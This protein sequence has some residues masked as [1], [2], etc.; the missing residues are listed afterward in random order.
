MTL[1]KL[2]LLLSLSSLAVPFLGC[3]SDKD[4]IGNSGGST[5]FESDSPSGSSQSG[6]GSVPSAAGP[7]ASTGAAA[8]D[9]SNSA[10]RAIE[11]A[12]IVKVENDRL[13]ALSQYG[14]LNIIDIST[15]DNLRLLGRKKVQ[16]QPFEMY[17]RDSIVFALY[18]GYGEYIEGS[19]AG[20]W[21]YIT[22][23]YVIAFDATDPTN[24]NII[25]KFAVPGNISDSRI[26]GDVLYVV[27]FESGGCWGC[28]S[29]QHTTVIS[30]DVST[31]SQITKRDQL[32]FAEDTT[33]QWSWQRSISVTDKRMYVAGPSYSNNGPVGSEIQ[34]ID[35]SD[36]KGSLVTG[37][38]VQASGSV[39]SRWQMD[40]FNGTLRV[41]S[42]PNQWL[43][44][45]PVRIQTYKV[46]S[47]QSLTQ[48]ANV[49]MTIPAGESLRSVRFDGP[50]GYAITAVQKDPLFTIDLSDPVQPRQAGEL[51]MPGWVYYMEPRGE[52]VVG[53]GYDQGN[54]AGALAISLFDVSTL[55]QPKLLDRVNFG[56]TWSWINEG[57]DQVHKAFQVLDA[58]NL[59][60]MPFSGWVT[61]AD[62]CS[63]QSMNGIQLVD[64]K[65]DTLGLRGVASMVG[66]PRRGLLNNERLFAMSDD[67]VETFDITDR[68][69]PA[70]K[71]SIKL[72]HRVQSTLSAG[73]TI[74]ELA[75][76][77]YS[78]TLSLDTTT[79]AAVESADALGH[80]DLSFGSGKC[81]GTSLGTVASSSNRA[82]LVV[83]DYSYNATTGEST[84]TA[85]VVTVDVSSP[86]SPR[87]IGEA[88][89]DF[90]EGWTNW[91]GGNLVN[92]GAQSVAI[93][94]SMVI[95]ST[96]SLMDANA[97]YIGTQSIAHVLDLTDPSKPKTSSF[98][99]GSTQGTTGLVASGTTL[100]VGYYAAS[101]TNAN[102]VRFYVDRIDMS[103]PNNPQL[104][105]PVNV[106]GSLVAFDEGSS[107]A[108]TADYRQILDTTV[109]DTEC[110]EKYP[111]SWFEYQ[112]NTYVTGGKGTCHSMQQTIHL[113]SITGGSATDRGSSA[114]PIGKNIT[115]IANGGD[116][117][118]LTLGSGYYYGGGIASTGGASCMDCGMYGYSSFTQGTVPLV[119]VGGLTSGNFGTGTLELAS[120]NYWGYSPMAASGSRAVLTTGW[121]GKLVVVDATDLGKPY[122]VRQADVAGSTQQI[123]VVG[124]TA[125]A[126]LYDDG[127]QT[128][129]IDN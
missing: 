104:L 3:A 86:A 1:R 92:T 59:I 94:N 68:S 77:W 114:L 89:L 29:G 62:G 52:R 71:A 14:G 76:D 105:A 103:A 40:E 31:P 8:Q 25:G 73:N 46:D 79:L 93:G 100:A 65:N 13:Y 28:Q 119:V 45:D 97:Q 38:K 5:V 120:G 56:G 53:L 47:A 87:V 33:A 11:E 117:L 122:V 9:S 70:K 90:G 110:Y 39:N 78:N 95:L 12:D 61:S 75:Q 101:P 58:S 96:K 118:F 102:K 6:K 36:P 98:N 83:N 17:V 72:T 88:A 107:N 15:R 124:G 81:G 109:T 48:L 55:S 18:N 63:S 106:P 64:W 91:Y 127:V 108:V 34:V 43:T 23:S 19:K 116:R 115:T 67:R 126:S 54:S 41:I 26:V 10:A 82:Y 24:P 21:S 121:Q 84:A 99:V 113:V 111:S 50:R 129:R 80:I 30:L 20:D 27:G 112:N 57:Q 66:N 128:I 35:I 74:L 4:P 125:I 69:T 16:A 85:R 51:V 44:A 2:T 37:T 60:L 49:P 32:S 22:T 123:T 7:T 42:Q